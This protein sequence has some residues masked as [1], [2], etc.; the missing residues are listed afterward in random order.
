MWIFVGSFFKIFFII[1]ILTFIW[2]LISNIPPVL[3]GAIGAII[4]FYL[5]SKQFSDH[6]NEEIFIKENRKRKQIAISLIIEFKYLQNKIEFINQSQDKFVHK[7]PGFWFANDD[8]IDKCKR[9][10]APIIALY[11]P[12]NYITINS[13][14]LDMGLFDEPIQKKILTIY[15]EMNLLSEQFFNIVNNVELQSPSVDLIKEIPGI[16]FRINIC[17]RDL[18]KELKEIKE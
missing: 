3:G 6:V 1:Y 13:I 17:I 7:N 12:K 8:S 11:S 14:K 15:Y 2:N 18:I 4:A 5:A 9:F 10:C 16:N